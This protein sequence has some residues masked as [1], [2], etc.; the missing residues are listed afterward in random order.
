MRRGD[1]AD[2]PRRGWLDAV[3]HRGRRGRARD[4]LNSEMVLLK[5]LL[6]P[7]RS[8][9]RADRVSGLPRGTDLRALAFLPRSS[10]VAVAGDSVGSN[11]CIT[12]VDTQGQDS[13]TVGQWKS[14]ASTQLT[15][16]VRDRLL[17]AAGDTAVALWSIQ[18]ERVAA[19]CDTAP[20]RIGMI[21]DVAYHENGAVAAGGDNGACLFH[22]TDVRTPIFHLKV[23][24]LFAD[25]P[26]SML[27]LLILVRIGAA[28]K[29]GLT[30]P[31]RAIS[32]QGRSHTPPHLLYGHCGVL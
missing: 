16:G 23:R 7:E 6:N 18:A 1:M 31:V 32:L 19:T 3:V 20:W 8:R 21:N 5:R 14:T 30:H 12:L 11:G 2:A 24:S 27:P 13:V 15:T 22:T 26:Q 25:R 17:V 4:H 28:R 29:R 10:T 9:V